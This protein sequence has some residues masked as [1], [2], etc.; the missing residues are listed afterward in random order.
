MSKILNTPFQNVV[1]GSKAS[2]SLP[3]GPTYHFVI[4][5]LVTLTKANLT[6]IK[7][8]LNTKTILECDAA[9]LDKINIYKGLNSNASFMVLDFTE[10]MAKDIV[11]QMAG[12]I[13]TAV[14]VSN[15][16]IEITI[17]GGATVSANDLRSWSYISGPI[18]TDRPLS[19]IQYLVAQSFNAGGAAT[20]DVDLPKGGAS[21]HLL[22]RI[23]LV[24]RSGAGAITAA[25]CRK[26]NLPI[27]E[28]LK[29]EN[30]FLQTAYEGVPDAVFYCLD[31]VM[32]NH[33]LSELVNT[34]DAQDLR[35]K[36]TTDGACVFDV[37]IESLADYGMI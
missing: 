20:W 9:T 32:M 1:A 33:T 4:I 31:F 17:A 24:K 30:E 18:N 34:K 37:F 35:L 25:D 13:P 21:A 6:N 15:F 23:W 11:S 7:I 28:T 22:K 14:G 8:R 19:N 2:L 3:I 10:M 12:V 26:N 29:A 16:N 27:L 5:Q 36:V